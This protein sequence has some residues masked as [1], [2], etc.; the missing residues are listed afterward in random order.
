MKDIP[1]LLSPQMVLAC[2]A[3]RKTTTRRIPGP[4][5]YSTYRAGFKRIWEHLHGPG[6]WSANPPVYAINFKLLSTTG[7]PV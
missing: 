5:N 2:L 1:L 3:G 4:T 6:S 7:K